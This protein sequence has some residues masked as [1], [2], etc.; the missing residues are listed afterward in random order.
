MPSFLGQTVNNTIAVSTQIIS[1]LSSIITLLI[2]FL[3]YS[4]YGVEKSLIN[5]Q[6]ET[7]FQLLKELKKTRFVIHRNGGFLQLFLDMIGQ[8]HFNEYRDK[9]LIFDMSYTNNLSNIRDIT[10]NIFLPVEIMDTIRP[11]IV[12]SITGET[13]KERFM[14]VKVSG[15]EKEEDFS[16][17]LNNK[18]ITLG[19]F[20]DQWI[21]VINKTKKWLREYSDIKI[22]LNFE[23][24]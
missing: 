2:A 24:N 22:D 7:V 17:K 20:M 10:E 3:L 6:T 13:D 23:R 19:E 8:N 14:I 16:G 15:G 5:K 1:A 11:L 12:L 18:D 4:K 21:L 9:S